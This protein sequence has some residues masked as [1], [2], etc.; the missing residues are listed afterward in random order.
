LIAEGSKP[1]IIQVSQEVA[2]VVR[3]S[4]GQTLCGLAGLLEGGHI[5]PIRGIGVPLQ[6]FVDVEN[7]GRL[8]GVRG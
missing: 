3:Y 1:V 8:F 2:S 6:G 4:F 7:P 5:E